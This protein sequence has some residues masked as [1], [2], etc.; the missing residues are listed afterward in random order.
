MRKQKITISVIG[1]SSIGT[2]TEDLAEVVADIHDKVVVVQLIALHAKSTAAE[3][4]RRQP[5]R[6]NAGER[7]KDGLARVADGFDE[8]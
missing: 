3:L 8:T 4:Q 1:G 7:V 2:R 6:A 5:A